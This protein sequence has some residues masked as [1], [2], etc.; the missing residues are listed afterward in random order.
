MLLRLLVPHR[1]LLEPGKSRVDSTL[2]PQLPEDDADAEDVGGECGVLHPE[3]GDAH[4][5]ALFAELVNHQHIPRLHVEVL[6]AA[7]MQVR[8][9]IRHLGG[10]L[11]HERRAQLAFLLA[12]GLGIDQAAEVAVAALEQQHVAR[13]LRAFELAV[14]EAERRDAADTAEMRCERHGYSRGNR[15]GAQ[16]SEI[17]SGEEEET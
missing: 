9:P 11:H 4:T 10:D 7:G 8:K 1:V 5:P 2:G 13:L 15:D 16:I 17:S 6:D 14:G 12:A 3:V